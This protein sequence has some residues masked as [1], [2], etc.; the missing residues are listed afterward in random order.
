MK[1]L[2]VYD[3]ITNAELSA[4][5]KEVLEHEDIKVSSVLLNQL[6]A[7]SLRDADYVL[8]L[9]KG[10]YY[11]GTELLLSE[12]V[13]NGKVM[14]FL[15]GNP[16][17]E[18]IGSEYEQCKGIRAFSF[19]D[20][21][22]K[23]GKSGNYVMRLDK[24]AETEKMFLDEKTEIVTGVSEMYAGLYMLSH[25][26]SRTSE[27]VKHADLTCIAGFY[28][29]VGR[30]VASPVVKVSYRSGGEIFLFTYDNEEGNILSSDFTERLLSEILVSSSKG[31]VSFEAE[32]TY[33]R[34][35]EGERPHILLRRH[36]VVGKAPQEFCFV[37]K[38]GDEPYVVYS[39][40]HAGR[41][42]LDI[43]LPI[44]GEGRYTVLI[45]ACL[46]GVC[47]NSVE[48][49][50]YILNE[51]RIKAEMKNFA[52]P[53]INQAN[54]VDFLMRDGEIMPIL[55]TTYFVTDVYQKCFIHFNV[56]ACE[57]DLDLL[58]K[59]GYNTLRSGNWM[60]H[61][62]FF[63]S[64]G[65]ICEK[66]RRALQAYFFMAMRHGFIVQFTLGNIAL[67]DWD[68]T[69][70][71]VHNPSINRKINTLFDNFSRLFAEYNNVIL[72][73][74]NE[75]S[76]SRKGA[77][78]TLRPSGDPYE[79]KAF[80]NF[81]LGEYGTMEKIRD[82][83][84]ENARTLPSAADITVPSDKDYEGTLYRT[85]DDRQNAK[86]QD[87]WRFAMVSYNKWLEGIREIVR[88]N[89]PYMLVIMGRDE[90]LRI[91]EEQDMVL[92][93][94][95]DMVSWHQWNWDNIV[96]LEYL[97]NHVKGHITCAQELGV[98]RVEKQRG[99]K[100]L[101]DEVVSGKLERKLMFGFGNWVMWQ[102]F[103][104]PEKTEL[105]ENMLG[106]YRA[107]R[108]ETPAASML[109]SLIAAEKKAAPFL[110][111]RDE[112]AFGA[113]T[114]YSTSSH[115]SLFRS[116]AEE[117]LRKHINV[118]NRKFRIQSDIV[119]EHLF[120]GD[121]P[122]IIGR[123]RIVFVPA[124]MRL[125][126]DAFSRLI[127]LAKKGATIVICGDIEENEMFSARKRLEMFYSES[128]IL[129]HRQTVKAY[130]KLVIGEKEFLLNFGR[131]VSYAD[132]ENCFCA[133]LEDG[134]DYYEIHEFELEEGRIIHCPLPIEDCEGEEVTEELYR[135][136]L[137]KAGIS[138]EVYSVS[139]TC[140]ESVLIHAISYEKC[141]AYS[142]INDG[143]AAEFEL[144]DL[145]SK[146]SV[147]VSLPVNTSAKIWIGSDG[148][149]IST[150]T[151]KGAAIEN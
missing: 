30:R 130:E 109:R 108:S 19:A 32:P 117:G 35:D 38:R 128:D 118:L 120:T 139:D 58:K 90:T 86:A 67:N 29:S 148:S 131:G 92:K 89:A 144:E 126:N 11:S 147:S 54:A 42:S 33:A 21:F 119:L 31:Q 100:C 65:K 20:T 53:Y 74:M 81:V 51:D 59:D 26:N 135:Y 39:V 13:R 94:N 48:T 129:T 146:K 114:L 141:T 116:F 98:Y 22:M 78:R 136:A 84:G 140:P 83:W 49:G 7:K 105:S 102:S 134:K 104:V 69:K 115:Y 106:V 41:H 133:L 72:D 2:I 57:R 142:M 95:L 97:M 61:T 93:G 96:Y 75:P 9:C 79:A 6:S 76:Y 125:E 85:E 34:F 113:L 12:F 149:V 56:A 87:F 28:D 18:M 24:T 107:D 145:R 16:F 132:T 17:S 127:I 99:G 63:G 70:C 73:V 123:P 50:F 137:S 15:G 91:P 1:A 80:M 82:A 5:C 52:R 25:E 44:T 138:N 143:A 122:E 14:I 124:A 111:H 112:E 121:Y 47:V 27:I 36:C 151:G 8:Y 40:S 66:S 60:M 55:G 71:A 110:F 101:S 10:R 68:V 23:T 4:K 37:V 88:E 64:D 3:E 43:E 77:W 45:R 46:G 103:N 150:Y 62:E